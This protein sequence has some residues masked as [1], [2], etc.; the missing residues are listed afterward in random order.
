MAQL[1]EFV[2]HARAGRPLAGLGLGA[3]GQSHLAEQDVAELL[4]AAR[5]EGRIAGELA[6]FGFEAGRALRELA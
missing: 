6:H 4:R 3:A 5:V 1:G 2:E